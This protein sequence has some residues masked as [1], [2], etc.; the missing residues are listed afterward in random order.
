M[1]VLAYTSGEALPQRAREWI[2]RSGA[3]IGEMLQ[4]IHDWLTLARLEQ[5]R[6]AQCGEVT[7]LPAL[8]QAVLEE[9]AP[10]AAA[11]EVT[12][13]CTVPPDLPAVRG[14]ALAVR[15]VL[16]NLVGNA[17]KYN[18][19]GGRVDV[20]ASRLGDG[21]ALEVEDTGIGIPADRLP[22]VFDE[23]VRVRVPETARIAGS[24][25]GLTICRTI[26]H[27]LGGTLGARS[28]EGAG[29]TFTVWLP[30]GTP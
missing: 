25:L 27:G 14:D 20:R 12:L 29:T 8:V 24:G 2:E 18:R 28:R 4:L 10:A 17:V 21:I 15:T 26:V 30:A 23:F 11:M 7:P 5:E 19:K 16:E 1:D 6:L 9:S 13:G 3:R 22:Q